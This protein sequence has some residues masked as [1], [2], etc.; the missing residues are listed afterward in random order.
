MKDIWYKDYIDT[1]RLK[2]QENI[3]KTIQSKLAQSLIKLK[4]FGF[5]FGNNQIGASLRGLVCRR[6]S[7]RSKMYLASKPLSDSWRI[8]YLASAPW[9]TEI[10]CRDLTIGGMWS[11]L[12]LE[13]DELQLSESFL[14]KT[15]DSSLLSIVEIKAWIRC[16]ESYLNMNSDSGWNLDLNPS[17]VSDRE[18]RR[19]PTFSL[20]HQN[21]LFYMKLWHTYGVTDLVSAFNQAIY[22][23]DLLIPI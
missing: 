7:R 17:W 13:L 23:T 20:W 8:S 10:Q 1:N 12:G 19:A 5:H 14:R 18:S 15:R 4:M 11:L 6:C 21:L 3:I 16:Y 2:S 9:Q 22:D